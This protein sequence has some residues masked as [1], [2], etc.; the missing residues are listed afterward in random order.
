MVTE[1]FGD[2]QS[3]NYVIEGEKFSFD[4]GSADAIVTTET[5]YQYS[6]VNTVAIHHALLHSGIKPGEV[7]VVVTLPLR[8]SGRGFSAEYSE[9]FAQEK[10]RET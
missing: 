9:Y 6:Q 2:G 1:S 3:S 10:Q 4:P 8:V 5:R 7:D